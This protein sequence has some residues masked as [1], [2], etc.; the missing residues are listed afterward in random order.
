MDKQK[1]DALTRAFAMGTS[2][3]TAIKGIFGGAV[4]VAVASTQ[5]DRAGAQATCETVEDCGAQPD[6]CTVWECNGGICETSGGCPGGEY[7]CPAQGGSCAECCTDA[8]C[9]NDTYCY[10]PGDPSDAYCVQCVSNDDCAQPDAC[11]LAA[12]IDN[13]CS[14]ASACPA[15]E[16]CCDV[17][18]VGIDCVNLNAPG[19]QY[20]GA[21]GVVCGPCETC[22]NGT[23]VS[24]CTGCEVCDSGTCIE[25]CGECE[26]CDSGTCIPTECCYDS[27]CP[28]CYFCSDEGICVENLCLI[29][30]ECCNGE[31]VPNGECCR[32]V[33][34]YCGVLEVTTADDSPQLDCCDGLVCC[35]NWNSQGSVCAECC[36][37]WDCAQG[38]LLPRGLVRISGRRVRPRQ[39]LPEGHLLL[40]GRIVLG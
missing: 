1:F 38:R 26:V 34:D 9:S 40:Q 33:G 37:D 23:C 35:E 7:C 3:R 22:N 25:D 27:D 15:G 13:I 28:D 16:T 11:T 4:G 30:E 29:G 12:C 19:D 36:N 18:G 32:G 14:T 17:D 10:N 31:C 39:G 24:T 2:R 20:C 6:S 5:L 21:C 8:E